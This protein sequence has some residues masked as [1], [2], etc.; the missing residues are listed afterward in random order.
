M[1]PCWRF[2]HASLSVRQ[3]LIPARW[4]SVVH[5]VFVCRQTYATLDTTLFRVPSRRRLSLLLHQAT[6]AN[7]TDVTA[8]SIYVRNCC[9]SSSSRLRL[10]LRVPSQPK[11][12]L[13]I[14]SQRL[15]GARLHHCDARYQSLSDAQRAAVHSPRAAFVIGARPYRSAQPWRRK[16]CNRMD[17]STLSYRRPR[18][19]AQIDITA[20]FTDRT[21]VIRHQ[22]DKSCASQATNSVLDRATRQDQLQGTSL[23]VLFTA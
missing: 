10:L 13:I 1:D 16:G 19:L 23:W 2:A 6:A 20:D 21:S 15:A 17:S 11:S 18:P 8:A 4:T 14:C 7:L 5:F 22:F 3:L 12:L 9:S